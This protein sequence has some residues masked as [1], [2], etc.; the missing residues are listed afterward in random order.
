MTLFA[1][2]MKTFQVA[3]RSLA[4]TGLPSDHTAFFENS[5]AIVSGFFFTSFGFEVNSRGTSAALLSR[6][7]PPYQMLLSTR[8]VA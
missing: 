8:D 4:V 2:L 5:K 1:G 7:W 3:L 6:I